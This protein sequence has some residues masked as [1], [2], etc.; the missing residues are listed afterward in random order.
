MLK[1]PVTWFGGKAR[2]A[3]KITKLFP[4]H[5]TYVDVFGGS[6]AILLSKKRSGVEVYNDIDSGLFNLFSVLR[7]PDLSEKL[8]LACAMTLYSRREFDL[9][10]SPTADPVES[11]R[12][13]L[14]RQRMSRAGLAKQWSYCV[15]DS[16][17]GISSAAKRWLSGIERLP[18]IRERLRGV[19]IESTD[20]RDALQRYDRED[21]L[22]YLDPPYVEDKRVSGKYLH[23]FTLSNHVELIQ[24]VSKTKGMIVLSGYQCELYDSL[25]SLGWDR[26]DFSVPAYSSDSRTRRTES[27]W[28]SF[29]TRSNKT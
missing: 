6:G 14:V 29:N 24:A 28:R 8:M 25:E 1:P 2:L 10:A 4:E 12:R 13:F 23:E 9:A 21:T 15:A 3:Q 16:C 20:W 26:V 17:G 19:Q 22:F 18:A 11:A 7:D 5:Q 27:V